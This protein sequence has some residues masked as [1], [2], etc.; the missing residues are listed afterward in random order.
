M[1]FL[2]V[3]VI[4]LNNPLKYPC[5]YPFGTVKLKESLSAGKKW[6][7]STMLV[8]YYSH[9]NLT[10]PGCTATIPSYMN[11]TTKQWPVI[12]EMLHLS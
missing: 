9:I 5:F 1:L 2:F 8:V 11:E 6:G 4:V 10:K 7:V 3:V 12:T